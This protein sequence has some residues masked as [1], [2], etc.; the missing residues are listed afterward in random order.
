MS[1]KNWA[2]IKDS[3]FQMVLKTNDVNLISAALQRLPT[4]VR[5]EKIRS[6]LDGLLSTGDE[7]SAEKI[8]KALLRELSDNERNVL[9]EC[10]LS[11][12][13]AS[14]AILTAGKMKEGQDS[15][16]AAIC[17]YQIKN[18]GLSR[19]LDILEESW[20]KDSD[21]RQHIIGVVFRKMYKDKGYFDRVLT[22][23]G[24]MTEPSRTAAL[25]DLL[26][27]KHDV[28]DFEKKIFALLFAE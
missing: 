26:E 10:F 18:N 20:T 11:Q 27:C 17:K 3:T 7:S 1:I 6:Y 15:A 12:N 22:L 13:Q 24:L 8:A 19:C 21:E 4:A 9:V 28:V 16:F 23:A 25:E 5:E 2:P 14:Y